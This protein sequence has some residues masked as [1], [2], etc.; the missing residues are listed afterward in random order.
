MTPRRRDAIV[1]GG[2]PNGLAAAALLAEHGLDVLLVEA[3]ERVGGGLASDELTLPGVTHDVGSAVHPLAL[4]SPYL[5]TLSL[6]EH[7]VE[8]IHPEIPV[9]HPVDEHR[10]AALHRSLDATAERLGRDGA[11]YRRLLGPFV[12][13]WDALVQEILA[14]AHLPRHPVLLAR[15]GLAGLRSAE[16][17]LRARFET[18]EARALLAGCAAH[19]FLPL[20]RLASA[21]V[22]LVLAAAGHA[23][24]WPVP[25]G[26][27][28]TVA[29]AL[30]VCLRERGVTI[31]TGRRVRRL[32]ELPPARAVLLDL[33]PRQVMAVAA[34]ELP[35]RYRRRLAGYRYGPAAYKLDWA[36]REPVPW[37]HDACVRAGTVHVGGTLEEVAASERAPARGRVSERPFVLFVQPSVFDPDRAP[38]GVHTAWAYCHVP[39]GFPGDAT[40]AIEAQVERFAPGFRDVIVERSV[41]TPARLESLNPN[42]V[43]G[44]INGGLQDLGQ[45]FTR[46][47]ARW[48]PYRTPSPRIFLCSSSTPPGGGVH[49]M[50][51]YH[52]GRSALRTVFGITTPLP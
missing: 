40:E 31:E 20:D 47:V 41:L 42:L 49:G 3:S 33:T 9:A 10:V 38:E 37:V 5:R 23:V 19:S 35:T 25:R 43:G 15:F 46:P 12:E 50:C 4:A 13:R 29:R 45:L 48:D 30:E 16:G 51:G 27:A 28:G 52:A 17:L 22:G 44:D 14:P 18:A 39:N 34:D 21:A 8:W 2:G 24:G 36:L 1:V 11:R 6:T 26:G 32:A 7:G